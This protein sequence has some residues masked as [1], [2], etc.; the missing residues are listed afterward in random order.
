L[1]FAALL[2]ASALAPAT[3]SAQTIPP[4]SD[5][6]AL[7]DQG[8]LHYDRQDWEAAR[9]SFLKAWELDKHPAI[10]SNLAEVEMKL[11]LYVEAAE[12]LKFVL[13]ALPQTV[14][15]ERTIA[16]Q[17]LAECRARIVS[18]R[19]N[20]S[21]AGAEIRLDGRPLGT[22]P[23]AGEVLVNPG[24][25]TVEA[26]LSGFRPALTHI[27]GR[28]GAIAHVDLQL[29]LEVR[30]FSPRP[31]TGPAPTPSDGPLPSARAVVIY[32]ASALA[33]VS[34][35][36]GV[37]Y[38]SQ[39]RSSGAE[40]RELREET[41]R[42]GDED[43]APRNQ[44]C[45]PPA[46]IRPAACGPLRNKVEEQYRQLS[47]AAGSFIAAGALGAGALLTHLLWIPE[48]RNPGAG[49]GPAFRAWASAEGGG[50]EL[51]GNL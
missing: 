12:H 5:A 21:V 40:A 30:N 20:V 9:R 50:I 45:A 42:T 19:I 38:W 34:A 10:A 28:P 44:Q 3:A 47:I 35:G 31:A 2:I 11:G 18:V 24:V 14:S 22:S 29:A 25:H 13:G 49:R 33:I 39:S 17:Q 51:Y 1:V 43:L 16:E 41:K 6:E 8:V 7:M 48:E 15:E 37:F 23:L 46:G 36:I 32:G 26:R 4:D 27:A